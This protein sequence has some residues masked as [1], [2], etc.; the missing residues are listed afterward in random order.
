[1]HDGAL[2]NMLGCLS[3]QARA[4]PAL[5]TIC[6]TLFVRQQGR[7]EW[8]KNEAIK[9][10]RCDTTVTTMATNTNNTSLVEIYGKVALG[11][12]WGDCE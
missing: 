2:E 3:G 9:S 4:I 8:F 6:Q 12:K 5:K 11:R 7:I 10:L 1:M